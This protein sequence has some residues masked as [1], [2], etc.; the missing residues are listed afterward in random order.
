M[1]NYLMNILNITYIFMHMKYLYR[2]YLNITIGS[3][4][5]FM[6]A[7]CHNLDTHINVVGIFLDLIIALDTV[8]HKILV[9]KLKN[10]ELEEYL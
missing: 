2:V 6:E 7:L 9:D 1:Q 4:T 5:L 3:L 8:G 10:V